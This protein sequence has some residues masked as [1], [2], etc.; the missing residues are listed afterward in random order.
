MSFATRKEGINQNLYYDGRR[1]GARIP[2]LRNQ[3]QSIQQALTAY[4]R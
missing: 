1:L 2:L 3:I 4:S